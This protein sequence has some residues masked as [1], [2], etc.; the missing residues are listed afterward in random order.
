MVPK[1]IRS[2]I[3]SESINTTDRPKKLFNFQEDAS[4]LF[5]RELMKFL[6]FRMMNGSG[7]GKFIHECPAWWD[8]SAIYWHLS[9]QPIPH[10]GAFIAHQ[11]PYSVKQF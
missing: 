10:Y 4:S 11:L 8:L 1:Y 5:S 3:L 7:I 9:G 2:N 6:F